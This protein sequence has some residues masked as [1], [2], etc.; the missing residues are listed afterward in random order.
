MSGSVIGKSSRMLHN[1]FGGIAG[2]TTAG[3]SNSR[4]NGLMTNSTNSLIKSH[5]QIGGTGGI[6]G[7]N[8]YNNNANTSLG[9]KSSMN[10]GT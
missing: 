9:I 6:R 2:S 4:N 8:I 3:Q 10:A 5:Q 1:E 7:N